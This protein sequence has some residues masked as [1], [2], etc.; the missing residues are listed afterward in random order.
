MLARTRLFTN[1]STT[2]LINKNAASLHY[3][4]ASGCATLYA[5]MHARRGSAFVNL[6]MRM[7]VWG[8][9]G[10]LHVCLRACVQEGLCASHGIFLSIPPVRGGGRGRGK[11]GGEKEGGSEIGKL[12]VIVRNKRW[13][14]T[15]VLT[16]SWGFLK[17][18]GWQDLHQ[19]FKKLVHTFSR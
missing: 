11:G 5:G 6:R 1:Q 2:G 7:C 8:G 18:S 10:C 13:S 12:H 14:K 15:V 16:R 3:L 4:V 19:T 17:K 9:G